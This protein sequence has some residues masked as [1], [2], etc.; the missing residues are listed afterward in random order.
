MRS[1]RPP[2]VP[3]DGVLRCFSAILPRAHPTFPFETHE[4]SKHIAKLI[5]IHLPPTVSVLAVPY[6]T[7]GREGSAMLGCN[8]D[9]RQPGSAIAKEGKVAPQGRCGN[10]LKIGINSGHIFIQRKDIS[11]SS[12][13]RKGGPR[14]KVAMGTLG[15]RDPRLQ[16]RT[17]LRHKAATRIL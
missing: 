13:H 6:Y 17:K 8:E 1:P 2:R 9:M 10:S 3:R 14:C 11:R 7:S 16:R 12:S 15:S 4:P 5:L